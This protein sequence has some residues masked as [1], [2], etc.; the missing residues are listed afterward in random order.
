LESDCAGSSGGDVGG[1]TD[2]E[3]S[4]RYWTPWKMKTLGFLPSSI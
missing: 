4:L 1:G 2:A 3:V